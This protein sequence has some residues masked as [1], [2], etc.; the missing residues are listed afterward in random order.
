M[1]SVS[2]HV[3]DTRTGESTCAATAAPDVRAPC[4]RNSLILLPYVPP[5]TATALEPPY[6]DA[7]VHYGQKVR[8]LGG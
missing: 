5:K 4:P 7:I 2:V 8:T 3:Q 1:R 6:D